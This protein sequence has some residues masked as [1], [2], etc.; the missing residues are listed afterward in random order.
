[1]DPCIK[2]YNVPFRSSKNSQYV[3]T[4]HLVSRANR[5]VVAGSGKVRNRAVYIKDKKMDKYAINSQPKGVNG[6]LPRS[7]IT[8]ITY[9]WLDWLLVPF[10]AFEFQ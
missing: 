9:G 5:G 4:L 3:E 10:E 8:H 1:M 2:Q 6:D 7:I